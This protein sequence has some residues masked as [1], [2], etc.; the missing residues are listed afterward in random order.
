MLLQSE[1]LVIEHE[2]QIGTAPGPYGQ[3]CAA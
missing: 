1:Q 3:S 2:A